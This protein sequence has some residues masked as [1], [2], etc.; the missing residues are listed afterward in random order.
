[1]DDILFQLDQPRLRLFHGPRLEARDPEVRLSPYPLY[2]LAL[3]FGHEGRPVERARIIHL[4]WG[5]DPS[6]RARQRLRQLV[7]T[8]CQRLPSPPIQAQGDDALVALEQAL[9]SD[10]ARFHEHLA[11]GRVASAGRLVR[12]GFL[13]RADRYP[14]KDYEDWVLAR[15]EHLRQVVY[16]S[17]SKIWAENAPQNEWDQCLEAAEA[18]YV[19][20]P[21]DEPTVRMVIEA[22]GMT[23]DVQAAETAYYILKRDRGEVEP[24]TSELIDRIRA[25]KSITGRV[26]PRREPV[27]LVGRSE[28][29]GELVSLLASVLDSRGEAITVVGSAG[30]GKSRLLDAFAKHAHL[31]GVLCLVAR[32]TEAEGPL[33][34]ATLAEALDNALVRDAVNDLPEPWT[35]VLS[36]VLAPDPDNRRDA[37]RPPPVEAGQAERRLYD[38]LVF[39]FRR[40]A[41]SQPTIIFIDDCHWADTTTKNALAYAMR[42]LKRMPFG[43]V[44]AERASGLKRHTPGVTPVSVPPLSPHDAEGLLQRVAPTLGPNLRQPILNLAGGHPFF[45]IELG[46]AAEAGTLRVRQAPFSL[47]GLPASIT[48]LFERQVVSL[49][50]HAK[51]LAE[52]VAVWSRPVSF[53]ELAGTSELAGPI[54]ADALDELASVG[55]VEETSGAFSFRHDLFRSAVYERLRPA[56]RALMHAR[57]AEHLKDSPNPTASGERAVHL[58][59][60]GDHATAAPL[61][62]GAASF[63]EKQGGLDE[64][65]FFY[66]IVMEGS[67]HVGLRAK[68]A[69]A[70]ARM[71]FSGRMLSDAL[72]VLENAIALLRDTDQSRDAIEFQAMLVEGQA[73]LGCVEWPILHSRIAGLKDTAHEQRDWTGLA[74]LLE[75]EVQLLHRA[76]QFQQITRVLDDATLCFERAEDLGKCIAG[77]VA[78]LGVLYGDPAAALHLSRS[79]AEAGARLDDDTELLRAQNRLLL[80]LLY[81]G[82]LYLPEGRRLVEQARSR[83]ARCG[84][85]MQRFH[86]DMNVGVF[87]MDAGDVEAAATS[88]RAAQNLIHGTEGSVYHVNLLYNMGELGL[89]IRDLPTAERH[90]RSALEYTTDATPS[91]LIELI[92]ASLGICAADQGRLREARR[93]SDTQV[94]ENRTWTFDPTPILELRVRVLSRSGDPRRAFE[95][96][97]AAGANLKGRLVP[98]WL[99]VKTLEL[100]L[101]RRLR[102]GDLAER[103]EEAIQVAERLKLSTRAAQ[104]RYLADSGTA[105]I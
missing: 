85:M 99:K 25:M 92:H 104:L 5:E 86:L 69:A 87:Q 43:I 22:R 103:T 40:L 72:P 20:D 49:S 64:A 30:I 75:A 13:S 94:L 19:M 1:M 15:S 37:S 55:I 54:L 44:M 89:T 101:A 71:L 24:E 9:P 10:L 79:A 68:A 61:A 96:V 11:K 4:M 14:T 57:V 39:L 58:A 59:R 60:I 38:A 16:T 29:L 32:G 56:H 91:Y 74:R 52:L 8:A 48:E 95:E 67:V 21:E 3:L 62:M 81:Q 102:L 82:R 27:P 23:G 28:V 26:R 47:S 78:A 70:L 53:W 17:A 36:D 2:L 80:V 100:K 42:R 83:A 84:D 88:L 76:S 90:L 77:R 35:S 33:P 6:P 63:A 105:R 51:A 31:R 65:R 12:L 73:E 66:E 46:R 50:E 34:L 98:A 97:Q 93:V 45:L 18:L 7:Y 41:A